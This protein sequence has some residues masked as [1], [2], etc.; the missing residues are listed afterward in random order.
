MFKYI[1]NDILTVSI[2]NKLNSM[3]ARNSILLIESSIF[4]Y[5]SRTGF[6]G[7]NVLLTDMS[8]VVEL[9]SSNINDMSNVLK[10]TSILRYKGLEKSNVFLII[11]EPSSSNQYELFVGVTRAMKNVEVLIIDELI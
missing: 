1:K 6:A 10:Y 8:G 9:K 7:L 4:N 11:R 3:S 2:Q 5:S